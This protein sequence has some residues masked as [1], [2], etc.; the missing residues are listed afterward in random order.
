[1]NNIGLKQKYLIKKAKNYFARLTY[2]GIDVSKSSFC[3][4]P[5]YGLNPGNTKLSEWLNKKIFSF[6]NIKII[7]IHMLAISS[8]YNYEASSLKRKK[9]K[10]LFISWGKKK[11]FKKNLFFDN[12][13]N[14]NSKINKN[15]IFFVIYLDEIRPRYIPE[16]VILYYKKKTGRSLIYLLKKLIYLLFK[17]RFN[18]RKFFHYFSSQTVFAE[19]I[20]KKI[21][22]VINKNDIKKIILPYEGQPFQNYLISNLDSDIKTYGVIHSILPALP[23]NLINRKGSP[24]YIY[25]S[26]NEQKNVLRN[27]LGWNKKKIKVIKSLRFKKETSHEIPGSIFLPI[28]L[29]NINQIVH[30][31]NNLLKIQKKNF[32]SPL[33]I[34]NHPAM[35]KSIIHKKLIKKLQKIIDT[36]KMIQ[37][38]RFRKKTCIFIGPTSS[39]IEY[40]EK[41]FNI[42]HISMNTIFDIYDNKIFSNIKNIRKKNF[43][44]YKKVNKR[45]MVLFGDKNYNFNKLKI[46]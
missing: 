31:F 27:F 9:Y 12:L 24:D 37:N 22:H 44:I 3:Y 41:N 28:N 26:S 42:I 2:I 18:L 10:N 11:N 43:F 38:N 45:C 1:M 17:Y 20:N 15:S 6:Q 30:D 13:L 25:V 16:N 21:R 14:V 5:S 46:I 7:L 4:I 32:S 34:R 36:N 35:N 8:Y 19:K 40:L 23:T 33:K 39:V 29:S